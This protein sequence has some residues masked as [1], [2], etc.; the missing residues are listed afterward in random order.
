MISDVSPTDAL[1]KLLGRR[2]KINFEELSIV[3]NYLSQRIVARVHGEVPVLASRG[4]NKFRPTVVHAIN[5]AVSHFCQSPLESAKCPSK[6]DEALQAIGRTEAER[7]TRLDAVHASLHLATLEADFLFTY[8]VRHRHL[9]PSAGFELSHALQRFTGHISQ[10]VALG[11]SSY[12]QNNAVSVSTRARRR[13]AARLLDRRARGDLTELAERANWP[14]PPEVVVMQLAWTPEADKAEMVR[15]LQ[16]I[17]SDLL[18][19]PGKRTMTVITSECAAADTIEKIMTVE[20]V[21]RT[22]HCWPVQLNH[23]GYAA[24]WAHRALRLAREGQIP[25]S[26]VIAC[27]DHRPLLW[28]HADPVLVEHT[29][30]SLLGPI[31]RQKPHSREVLAETLLAFLQ[32]RGS[33]PR[34]AAMLGM[35]EQT[36]RKRMHRLRTL[37]GTKLDDPDISIALIAALRA[38]PKAVAPAPE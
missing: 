18:V 15:A 9:P 12:L 10:Q 34:L 19:L 35:H 5:M 28:L 37:Y 8:L 14:I 36:I 13:L 20:G 26:N 16:N 33:A 1:S 22:A 21:E 24:S 7:G 27:A 25:D 3:E 38:R 30:D 17:S 32:T 23:V 2:Q 11:Y 4:R 31:L 6:L 29:T